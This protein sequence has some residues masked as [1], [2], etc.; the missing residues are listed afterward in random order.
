M[1][2]RIWYCMGVFEGNIKLMMIFV[3]HGQQSV[4]AVDGV[5]YHIDFKQYRTMTIAF[6]RCDRCILIY[7]DIKTLRLVKR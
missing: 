6:H 1:T 5:V 3:S 2:C 4:K 7:S